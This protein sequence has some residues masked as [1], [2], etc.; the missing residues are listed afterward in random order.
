M[1]SAEIT[2][3]HLSIDAN[4]SSIVFPGRMEPAGEHE[5]LSQALAA[6]IKADPHSKMLVLPDGSRWRS[7]RMRKDRYALRRMPVHCPKL[8]ELK[9]P[10]W[11][12]GLLLANKLKT[13]GGLVLIL[14]QTGAGKTT[15]MSA[16]IA[17]RLELHGGYCL[18]LEDPPEHPLEGKH[19]KSGFCEQ[20][21]VDELGGYEKAI[22]TALRCFPA[23]DSSMLVYG[24]IRENLT[25][26]ELVRVAVDG[27]LVFATM[28]AR[29]IPEGIQR[30]A[31]MA[32][33]AGEDNA[34]ALLS[35]ALQL[36]VHQRFDPGETLITH[37]LPRENKVSKH[38]HDGNFAALD[39]EVKS[40]VLQHMH[41]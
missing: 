33:M 24:E 6:V 30:L 41:T 27:H 26:A 35:T 15:S 23:K 1:S 22:Y 16:T 4:S 2:D 17:A 29:S 10:S 9:I 7:Q 37:A 36:A 13:Q 5:E 12:K 19:G 34:N 20:L 31:A 21:D 8:D 32:K 40:Q 25:A 14:G 11:I 3:I 39:Q 18:T 28:H 38:I